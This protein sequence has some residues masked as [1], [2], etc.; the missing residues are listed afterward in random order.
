MLKMW[1]RGPVMHQQLRPKITLENR[2]PWI[3]ANAMYMHILV[4]LSIVV[5][6]VWPSSWWLGWKYDFSEFQCVFFVSRG[7]TSWSP[8][9]VDFL[10]LVRMR[11]ETPGNLRP[12]F[13][14]RCACARKRQETFGNVFSS[15]LLLPCH[16]S[17]PLSVPSFVIGKAWKNTNFWKLNRR[18]MWTP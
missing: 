2:Y 12:R 8:I 11:Q 18:I 13:F 3:F 7:G 1:A 10:I 6:F 15:L 4:V 5:V 17:L 16:K 14:I 9:W